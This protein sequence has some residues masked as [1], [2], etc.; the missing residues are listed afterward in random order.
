MIDSY[1]DQSR[2]EE[3]SEGIQQPHSQW[4]VLEEMSV[5]ASKAL[6]SVL[7]LSFSK[8]I[9]L[10]LKHKKMS[11]PLVPSSPPLVATFN[12]ASVPLNFRGVLPP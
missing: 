11:L 4:W 2:S 5:S 12:A 9:I 6:A 10:S 1:W 3:D 7:M 8:F